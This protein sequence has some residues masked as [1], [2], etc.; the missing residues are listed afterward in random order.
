MKEQL[1]AQVVSPNSNL[2]DAVQPLAA[3]FLAGRKTPMEVQIE[4]AKNALA[5]QQLVA[6]QQDQQKRVNLQSGLSS[7]SGT[8]DSNNVP[9]D[10]NGEQ[11]NLVH[12]ISSPQGQEALRHGATQLVQGGAKPDE[13]QGLFR[14][15]ASPLALNPATGVNDEFIQRISGSQPLGVDQSLSLGGQQNIATRNA[16]LDVYKANAINT[17]STANDIKKD[18]AIKQ[19][20]LAIATA[21][22]HQQV[23]LIVDQLANQY[24]ALNKAGAAVNTANPT[25]NNVSASLRTSAAGQKLGTLF[26][27]SDQSIRNQIQ[28]TIPLL[29]NAI[30]QSTGQ[31]AKAMDSNAELQ[32]YLAAATDQTKDVQS[33]IAALNRIKALYGAGGGNIPTPGSTAHALTTP[34]PAGYQ[35]PNQVVNPAATA[36]TLN[37][38]HPQAGGKP[39]GSEAAANLL[40][41]KFGAQPSSDGG[42]DSLPQGATQVG[43]SG[44]K[45][46]FQTPD[47][48]KFIQD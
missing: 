34:A 17:N 6:L 9:L 14:T 26:G 43:T 27:T 38:Y 7:V 44:G 19:Q 4:A 8:F 25:L 42:F 40:D 35:A 5:Q 10:A 47:G 36:A 23:N 12:F 37:A 22:P 21:L 11:Q 20:D 46:V 24:D 29:M 28:A 30:R 1:A 45:P 32:F 16:G 2:V 48:R 15:F 31:S 3:A 18:A 39:S 41:Q 13:I 33:N